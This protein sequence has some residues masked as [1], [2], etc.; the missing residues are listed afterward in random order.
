MKNVGIRHECIQD[1]II[2]ADGGYLY[3]FSNPTISGISKIKGACITSPI[4][5]AKQRKASN[6]WYLVNFILLSMYST[7]KF[8]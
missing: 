5:I 1:R 8:E 2:P 6:P 4:S 7:I 3:A